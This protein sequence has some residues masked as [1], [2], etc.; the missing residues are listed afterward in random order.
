MEEKRQIPVEKAN[1]LKAENLSHSIFFNYGSF[2][3][4]RMKAPWGRRE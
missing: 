2:Q 4:L 3:Y 1:H